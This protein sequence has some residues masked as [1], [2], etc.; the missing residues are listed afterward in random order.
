MIAAARGLGIRA[1]RWASCCWACSARLDLPALVLIVL[2]PPGAAR[3]VGRLGA[4]GTFRS[5]LAMM[6][7][8]GAWRLDL[9]SLDALKDDGALIIAPNHPCLLDAVLIVSRLPNAMCV[10]KRALLGNILLGPGARLAHYVRNDSLR[11]LMNSAAEELRQGAQLLLFPEGTRSVGDPSGRS[12]TRWGGIAPCERST[13]R[14][15]EADSP[16]GG[17]VAARAAPL[18][19]PTGCGWTALRSA[20]DVRA[21]TAEPSYFTRELAAQALSMPVAEPRP[22]RM[23]IASVVERSCTHLVLIPSYNPGAPVYERCA[24]RASGTV[25][26]DH[27]TDA[28]AR[29]EKLG[30]RTRLRVVVLPR[31]GAGA[32]PCCTARAR[33]RRGLH[34]RAHHGLRQ[35]ASRTEHSRVHGALEGG[36]H[37]VVLGVPVFD[38]CRRCAQGRRVSTGGRTSDDRH[39]HRDSLYGFR[40]YPTPTDRRDAPPAMDAPVRLT[41]SACGLC[42]SAAGT[43]AGEV[44][45]ARGGG[46][47][48][49]AV[50]NLLLTWMHLRLVV[51]FILRLPRCCGQVHA[52]AACASA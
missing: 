29:P 42:A 9:S 38:C 16:F 32:R 24:A 50:H 31:N 15:H 28:A 4:M 1:A 17:P 45:E 41:R 21:F 5:Y 37:A 48:T 26:G 25:G 14:L 43:C 13:G 19:S 34:A 2:L 39:R 49:S 44:P 6:E 35:P 22:V 30:G 7:M 47:L 18:P 27:S 8:L 23:P 46:G 3:K 51:E 11:P 12:P 33:G 20:Q 10:M 40:V 36:A 52:L